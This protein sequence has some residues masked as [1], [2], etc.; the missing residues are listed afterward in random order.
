MVTQSSLK[1]KLVFMDN[2]N[3]A[4]PL[5]KKKSK[6]GPFPLSNPL[7]PLTLRAA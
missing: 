6:T 5:K 4:E 3:F 1:L 7:S 2:L